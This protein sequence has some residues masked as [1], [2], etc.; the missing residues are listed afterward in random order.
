MCIYYHKQLYRLVE[1]ALNTE[2]KRYMIKVKYSYF[3][4]H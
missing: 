2:Q 3:Y 1:I 4:S